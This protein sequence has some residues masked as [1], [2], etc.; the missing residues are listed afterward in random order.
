M[1]GL[2]EIMLELQRA[3]ALLAARIEYLESLE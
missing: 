1:E 3:I 2:E